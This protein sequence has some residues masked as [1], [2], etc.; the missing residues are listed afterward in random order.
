MRP[1]IT[2]VS[3]ISLLTRLTLPKYCEPRFSNWS[4]A[5]FL[6]LY[7]SASFYQ[8]KSWYNAKFTSFRSSTQ[9]LPGLPSPSCWAGWLAGNFLCSPF[10]MTNERRSTSTIFLAKST[11]LK[12]SVQSQSQVPELCA[13]PGGRER[14]RVSY[15]YIH[16]SGT[17]IWRLIACRSALTLAAFYP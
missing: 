6:Y 9:E 1:C 10:W 13:F 12:M 16:H 3:V 8:G 15:G 17:W 2:S 4:P 7:V 5:T 14:V 11:K